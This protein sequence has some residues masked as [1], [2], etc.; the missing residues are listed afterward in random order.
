MQVKSRRARGVV[1]GYSIAELK[2]SHCR[3]IDNIFRLGADGGYAEGARPKV[4]GNSGKARGGQAWEDGTGRYRREGAA[5]VT[6]AV[7]PTV[8]N[9]ESDKNTTRAEDTK[10]FRKHLIL[11]L[12]GFEVVENKNGEDGRK[13]LRSKRQASTIALHGRESRSFVMRL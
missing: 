7:K 3:F 6:D 12:Y 8:W 4:Q 11:Q 13:R 1:P 9:F 5:D 2:I 10:R